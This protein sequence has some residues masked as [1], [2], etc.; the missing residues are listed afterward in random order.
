MKRF[1]IVLAGIGML[2]LMLASA[3]CYVVDPRGDGYRGEYRGS[4]GHYYRYDNRYDRDRR[5][6]RDRDAR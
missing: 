3:G 4:D 2:V 6:D 5:I 1:G